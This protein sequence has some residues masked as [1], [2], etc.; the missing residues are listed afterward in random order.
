MFFVLL[1]TY[2]ETRIFRFNDKTVP[3]VL[4]IGYPLVYYYFVREI[5]LAHYVHYMIL[6][7]GASTIKSK[8]PKGFTFGENFV[9]FGVNAWYFCYFIESVSRKKEVAFMAG[10]NF[11]NSLIFAPVFIFVLISYSGLS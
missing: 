4:K 11:H 9:A 3:N 10:Y 5:R 1:T 6:I 2:F 8:L 7:F